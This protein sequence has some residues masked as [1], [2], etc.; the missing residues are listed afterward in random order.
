MKGSKAKLNVRILFLLSYG[1]IVV[2]DSKK[3]KNMDMA[4][5]QITYK[6]NV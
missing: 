2:R 5:C 1:I 6:K 3:K 4:S